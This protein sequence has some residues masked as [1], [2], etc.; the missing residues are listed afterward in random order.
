LAIELKTLLHNLTPGT[1]KRV[2]AAKARWNAPVRDAL[3]NETGLRLN[4][5]DKNGRASGDPLAIPI[6]ITDAIP[7]PIL[8]IKFDDK[9]QWAIV[10][11]KYRRELVAL[12]RSSTAI[13]ALFRVVLQKRKG[14][15]FLGKSI[16]DLPAVEEIADRMLQEAGKCDPVGDILKKVNGDVLG[17]YWFKAI[18]DPKVAE[19][20]PERQD[21]K[22]HLY[23][24]VIGFVAQMLNLDT[25][26]LAVVVLAHELAHAYTHLG[27]DIDGVRWSGTALSESQLEVTEGLAQ[28]YTARVCERLQDKAPAVHAAY[29]ELLKH[30][31][32]A[33]KTHEA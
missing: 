7:E 30:Q 31:P 3:R 24:A 19:A 33:Y 13:D 11:R 6:H 1:K 21:G 2:E 14:D 25:E 9:E 4:S 17:A 18:R 32:D 20:H 27:A 15:E 10:L 12:Q 22:I 16:P 29:E 5:P 26:A 23:W 8:N 28:Y